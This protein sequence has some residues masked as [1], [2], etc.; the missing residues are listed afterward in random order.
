M[1]TAMGTGCK[2][3]SRSATADTDVVV[4]IWNDGRIGTFRGTRSGKEG[5]GGI[6]FGT[7]GQIVLGPFTGYDPLL[8]E[9]VRFFETGTPPVTEAET[10]EILAFMEAADN[11]KRKGGQ[12]V[13]LTALLK[14]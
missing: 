9:I 5:Y 2:T 4:G 7:T 11:S 1:F 13:D 8:A 12:P 6:V 14:K 10:L 3:V